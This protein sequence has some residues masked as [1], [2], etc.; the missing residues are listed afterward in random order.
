MTGPC[1]LV[2]GTKTFTPQ[3]CADRSQSTASAVAPPIA[4]WLD[5][6]GTIIVEAPLEEATDLFG[7]HQKSIFND[8]G[9]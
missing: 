3:K 5:A 7:G 6:I 2:G 1:Y 9:S 4:P 8:D